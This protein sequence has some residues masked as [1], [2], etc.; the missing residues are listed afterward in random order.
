MRFP[1]DFQTKIPLK[2][3]ENGHFRMLMIT[4]THHRPLKGDTTVRAMDQLIERTKP[5]FVFLG[6][7]ITAGRA[8]KEDFLMLLHEVACPMEKRSIPWAH[9][10]GNHDESPG[11]E[12]TYQET[13]FE[14]L[15]HCVSKAGPEDL[16]GTGNYF[17]PILKRNGEVAFGIWALDSMQDFATQSDP[18][19]YKGDFYYDVLMPN[20]IASHSDSDFIRFEQVMWY[21]NTSGEIEKTL[22]RKLPSLMLFHIPLYEINALLQNA[23]RTGMTG[24]YNETVSASEINSGM[25]AAAFQRGDVKGIFCGHD[26]INTFSGTYCGI[27]MGFCG[28]CGYEAYGSRDYDPRGGKN[29]LRGGRVFDFTEDDPAS[30]KTEM[31][32]VDNEKL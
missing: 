31:I 27:Q 21:Y 13:E 15:P 23:D 10:F 22:G 6:G 18:L 19:D 7:D 28:S 32:F 2:F 29:R 17:L 8:T 25:F 16:P 26:H 14:R 24:E 1:D 9:V 11:L 20:R 3:D 5:D 30:F 12:K 4:D